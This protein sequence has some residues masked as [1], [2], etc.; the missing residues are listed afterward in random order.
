MWFIHFK[1]DSNYIKRKF[2]PDDVFLLQTHLYIKKYNT[3]TFNSP[4]F[5]LPLKE[6]SYLCTN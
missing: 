6:R 3:L 4:F 1:T 5:L 2:L